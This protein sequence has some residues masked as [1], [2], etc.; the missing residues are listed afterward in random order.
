MA[1][2]RAMG[3]VL[4]IVSAMEKDE[5]RHYDNEVFLRSMR[6]CYGHV[7]DVEVMQMSRKISRPARLL[8]KIETPDSILL[9]V[10]SAVDKRTLQTKVIVA[11]EDI[12]KIAQLAGGAEEVAGENNL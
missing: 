4:A 12:R 8:A 7:V 3:M 5:G 9:T 10:V 2:T 1:M 6:F 11:N